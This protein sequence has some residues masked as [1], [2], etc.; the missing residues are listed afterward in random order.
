MPVAGTVAIVGTAATTFGVH[1]DRGYLSLVTEAATRAIADANL[2]VDQI[3]AAWLATAAP[4]LSSLEGDSGAVLAEALGSRLMPVSRVS[5]FCASGM[6]AIRNAAFAIAAGEYETALVVGAEKMRDV[7]PRG[8][9]VS[10]NG[11]MTH[12]TMAKGRSGPGF[13]AL[14]ASRYF[15]LYDRGPEDL[16]R[17]AVKNHEHA[18]R[19]PIAQ[20]STPVTAEQ[21][22]AS[23]LVADPLRLLD[24]TPTTDGA[25]AVVLATSAW[26]EARGLPYAVIEGIGFSVSDGMFSGMFNPANDLQGFRSTREA[27]RTA[28]QQA[29]IEDPR[30][31]L[32]L[33]E[34]HDCFT[35]T[36]LINYEDLGLCAPGEGWKLLLEGATTIGGDIPV[37]LSGGL[38]SCGHPIGATGLRV[39]KEVADHM[40]GR[41]GDRQV[42][43]PRR[44]VA[45]TLGGPGVLSCVMVIGTGD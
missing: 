11:N 7:T 33:V 21:V 37:N 27:A 13:F 38:Q 20:Y 14:L 24:C 40:T 26:A 5:A 31:D 16:A 34:C 28:Y 42:S 30:R 43:D 3:G 25:A 6:D 44:G 36:E 22:L 23:P 1:H 4:D 35:I 45:H 15:D 10:R 9:L 18:T 41:A 29:G 2:E 19:N 32:D 39:V 12:P 17:V 8:S